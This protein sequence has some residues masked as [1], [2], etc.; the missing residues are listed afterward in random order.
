MPGQIKSMVDR[1]IMERAKGDPILI[2]TTKTKLMLKGINPDKYNASSPD[3]PAV[4]A[5][6]Q[7]LAQELNVKL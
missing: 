3:D 6:L 1:I 7:K 5:K 4:I 2:N